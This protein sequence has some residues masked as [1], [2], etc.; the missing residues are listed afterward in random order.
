[1]DGLRLF[2]RMALWARRR[3]S[4]EW[5]IAAAAVLAL[6]AVLG[7]IEHTVGWPDWL[8]VNKPPRL[9]LR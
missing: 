9:P 1:M 6:A 5:M 4:K 7:T 8:T 2:V 3:P